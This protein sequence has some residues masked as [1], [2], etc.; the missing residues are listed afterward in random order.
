MNI[1]KLVRTISLV[2]VLN[3]LIVINIYGKCIEQVAGWAFDWDDN[4]MFMPTKVILYHKTTNDII[5]IS[6]SEFAIYNSTIGKVGKYSDFE[7]RTTADNNSFKY[8]RDDIDNNTNYF[9]T[10]VATTLNDINQKWKGPSWDEF[11][12][13]LNNEKAVQWTYIVTARGHSSESIYAALIYM[14]EKGIIKYLPPIDNI[15]AVSNL[16]YDYLTGTSADKKAVVISDIL[17]K[18][19]SC[20][21]PNNINNETVIDHDGTSLQS[22]HVFGFSDDDLKNYD[23]IKDIISSKISD[24]YWQNIKISLFYTGYSKNDDVPYSIVLTQNGAARLPL[25]SE[26]LD[27]YKLSKSA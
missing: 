24:G 25:H 16:K 15:H 4:I 21:M 18:I 9:L 27:G 22:L 6:T 13:A 12:Y 1:K 19:T 3:L 17:N 26:L 20:N 10:D 23:T 14:K 8:F 5:T 2:V 11:I 7:I